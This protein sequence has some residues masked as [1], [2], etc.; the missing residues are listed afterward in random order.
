MDAISIILAALGGQA[1]LFAAVAWLGKGLLSQVL[2]KQLESFKA[3]LS[4]QSAIAVEQLKHELQIRALERQITF[5]KLH[6][7]R[8]EVIASVYALIIDANSKAQ[9]F[10]SSSIEDGSQEKGER[11]LACLNAVIE[12][13]SFFSA[14][15]IY[16]P[17]SLGP[18][19]ESYVT[20]LHAE[21][22]GLAIYTRH[23]DEVLPPSGINKKFAAW[24]KANAYLQ[25][26]L[27]VALSELE[28][29]FRKILGEVK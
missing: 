2:A 3:S 5:G 1:L 20:R 26:E 6:E 21:V 13:L 16:L 4:K 27:P 15:K 23:A 18:Q 12:L 22:V 28:R 19:V 11:Y 7:R 9:Q 29:E 10:A 8:A 14:H 25:N 17:E 24:D